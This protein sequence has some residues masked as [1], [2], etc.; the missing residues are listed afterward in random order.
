M[1]DDEQLQRDLTGIALG[2]LEGHSFALAGSGAIRE[3]GLV[4]RLT[5]DVD[6]FTNSYDLE[7]FN[8]AVDGLLKELRG[9]GYGVDELRRDGLFCQLVIH[10]DDGRSVDMDLGYD[11]RAQEPARLALG[12]VLNLEDAV[13]TKV[14]ALYSRQEARDYID[15]DAIRSS[16]RFTDAELIEATARR[17]DGFETSMFIRQLEQVIHIE[18]ERF[19]EYGVDES[20]QALLTSRFL[21]WAEK[22]RDSTEGATGD[23][24]GLA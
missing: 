22:L 8:T 23:T 16:G 14:N 24:A 1:R 6:L 11:W 9:G 3:H 2:A 20:G 17:D 5:H 4:D 19:A 21:A 7:S 10:T 15:V 18:P 13:A 12:P